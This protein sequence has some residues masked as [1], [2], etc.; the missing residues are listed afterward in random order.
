M[1]PMNG[2]LF[3]K[4]VSIWERCD[5]GLQGAEKNWWRGADIKTEHI[6]GNSLI[7]WARENAPKWLN[8]DLGEIGDGQAKE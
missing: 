4:A 2:I 1:P 6:P 7:R 5:Q 8:F 3:V